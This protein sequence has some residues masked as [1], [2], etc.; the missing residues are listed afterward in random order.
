[1]T[2]C[3]NRFRYG[4]MVPCNPSSFIKE[5]NPELIERIDLKKLL[6]TPV[7][8]P[9]AKSRFAAMRAAVDRTG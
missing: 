6:N 3:F 5:L 7:E 1:M 4:G 8:A 9:A 2:Y